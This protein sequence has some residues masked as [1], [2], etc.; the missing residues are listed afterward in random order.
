MPRIALQLTPDFIKS[1][2]EMFNL[3]NAGDALD[4]YA[5]L[6]MDVV[7]DTEFN[8]KLMT[9]DEIVAEAKIDSDLQIMS[10]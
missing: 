3:D 1:V 10:L 8:L 7:G 6:V 4:D 5:Y 9:E 2:Y